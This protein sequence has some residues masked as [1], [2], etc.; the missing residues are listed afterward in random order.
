MCINKLNLNRMRDLPLRNPVMDV[1]DP[2]PDACLAK[3]YGVAVARHFSQG[4]FPL[5]QI[6]PAASHH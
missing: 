2:H 6:A 3:Y 5:I 4:F 1:V